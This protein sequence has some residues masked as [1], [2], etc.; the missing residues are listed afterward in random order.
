[1]SQPLLGTGAVF[2]HELRLLLY[3]PL[4]YLFQT[5]ILVALSVSVFLIADFYSTDDA[6]IRQM[7]TFM[8]WVALIFVPA[9]AMR[10]W[11]DEHSDRGVEL[12]LTLPVTLGAAVLGKFLA[13]YLVLL[14]TLLFTLP[15]V[16]TIYFLGDPDPGVVVA[17]YIALAL[18]LGAYYAVALL[19]GALAREQ[20]GAFVIGV[21]VL[22]VL[23]LLGWDV[24]ARALKDQVS[25]L[26][27]ET[28]RL[29]S[30]ATWVN[31]LSRGWID[32]AGVFY[33][34]A[35]IGAS[36]VATRGIIRYRIL[37]TTSLL[38]IPKMWSKALLGIGVLAVAIP[39]AAE[40]PGGIDLTA[41]KE[42][43]PHQGSLD[44]LAK[45]PP[46]VVNTLYWSANESS[47]PAPIKSHARKVQNLLKT[48]TAR[49]ARRMSLRIVDPLP[50]TDEALRAE[51]NGV[52]R[53]AMSSG[54]HFYLGAT[55]Q[56]ADRLGNIA[57]LD[58]RRDRFI[59]Y[60]IA[61]AL[62]G[63][64]RT[65]TPKL[66]IISPLIPSMAAIAEREGM[67]FMAELKREYDVAAAI[68]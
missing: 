27:I 47:V 34:L 35:I 20:V 2:R 61:V 46:D 57:Y 30:P 51:A 37:G 49:A 68:V 24:F 64:T 17:G 53:I 67:S 7:L 19:A 32:V 65:R 45:L 3:A 40:L 29:Y 9:L 50:D 10:A 15:L 28:M 12:L 6:T 14:V 1:M 13:G 23:L 56:H 62:N 42:F 8:P 38:R 22:F 43:T 52:R 66:G 36:L 33:F 25:P 4:S 18:M 48:L 39:F 31:L 63:L 44:V 16:G 5:A 41:E 58:P 26:L 55:F 59:E 21:I 11:I 54:D 60:D